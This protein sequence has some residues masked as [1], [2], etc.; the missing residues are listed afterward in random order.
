MTLLLEAKTREQVG[1]NIGEVRD[2]GFI[3]A[4]LYGHGITNQS[5]SIGYSQFEK[6][7]KEAGESSLVDLQVDG[8]KTVKVLV[9]DVQ[10]DAVKHSIIH[11]DL[12]QVKMDEKINAAIPLV[13]FGESPVVKELG[14][15]IVN[16]IEEIEVK[17]LPG[18]L[19]KEIRVDMQALKTFEDKILVKDLEAPSNIEVLTDPEVVVA[20]AV[21]VRE[22]K[23]ETPVAAPAETPVAAPAED[24]K[25]E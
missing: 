20:T 18:D 14:G 21:A 11:A 22:E 5:L 19:V 4:V 25:T 17:C 2:S 7:Y 15:T 1:K 24:K 23:E 8:G 9:A 13:F 12:Y 6:I 3:P 10:Y 16:S